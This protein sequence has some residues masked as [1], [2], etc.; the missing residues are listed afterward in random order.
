[1]ECLRYLSKLSRKLLRS[2]KYSE[3]K[4]LDLQMITN[5]IDI[6]MWSDS[7]TQDPI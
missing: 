6:G 5:E 3:K 2:I 4:E 7:H 1:M